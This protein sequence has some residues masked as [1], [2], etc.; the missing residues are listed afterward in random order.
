MD[1]LES[2][3]IVFTRRELVLEVDLSYLMLWTRK[4]EERDNVANGKG[5]CERI[6]KYSRLLCLYSTQSLPW[7]KKWYCT[8]C[9][10][11]VEWTRVFHFMLH[12]QP[13]TMISQS[14][15]LCSAQREEQQD[16][17]G[18]WEIRHQFHFH[19]P[20]EHQERDHVALK[21]RN[22]REEMLCVCGHTLKIFREMFTFYSGHILPI[23]G[24]YGN[25]SSSFNRHLMVLEET[26]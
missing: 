20:A 14:Q 13:A 26:K 18:R 6:S 24:L 23:A 5:T 8:V 15:H 17:Y 2:G 16:I 3:T 22:S 12:S 7:Y 4:N 21:E 9:I 10:L 19:Y 11:P 25:S 1:L